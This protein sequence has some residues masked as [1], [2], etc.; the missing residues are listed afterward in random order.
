MEGWRAWPR[1]QVAL[2]Y[3]NSLQI[4]NSSLDEVRMTSRDIKTENWRAKKEKIDL[5][6]LPARQAHIYKRI[7]AKI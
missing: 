6:G 2:H 1:A 7:P 3:K 5:Q 4:L